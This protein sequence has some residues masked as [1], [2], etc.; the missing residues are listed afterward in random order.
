MEYFVHPVTDPVLSMNNKEYNG[1]TLVQRQNEYEGIKQI[2]HHLFA[3][4]VTLFIDKFS[5]VGGGGSEMK[6]L[7]ITNYKYIIKAFS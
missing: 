1:W 6:P 4:H 7:D 2:K 3:F 5:P